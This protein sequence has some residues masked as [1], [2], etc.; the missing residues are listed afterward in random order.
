[1]QSMVGLTNLKKKE[2]L[3]KS[4]TTRT[5]VTTCQREPCLFSVCGLLT[6]LYINSHLI[7]YL[8]SCISMF[9]IF[10]KSTFTTP[11]AK[12][13][14]GEGRYDLNGV[15]VER[16]VCTNYKCV[17]HSKYK[18][19]PFDVQSVIYSTLHLVVY[20]YIIRTPFNLTNYPDT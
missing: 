6:L 5:P 16:G 1:M 8:L 9:L 17:L 12:F 20:F 13:S 2:L 15:P 11:N 7:Y 18:Q 19:T 4:F 10:G 14:C 3:A